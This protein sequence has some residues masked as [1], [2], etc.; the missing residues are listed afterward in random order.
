MYSRHRTSEK[1][2]EKDMEDPLMKDVSIYISAVLLKACGAWM[3][4]GKYAE[5]RR[6]FISQYTNVLLAF[7][8]YVNMTDCYYSWGDLGHCIFVCLIALAIVLGSIKYA[9]LNVRR[10]AVAD[11]LQSARKLIWLQNYNEEEKN[12]F[13]V[14]Q[15]L[16]KYYA[17]LLYWVAQFTFIGYVSAPLIANIGRNKS[18]RLF[19]YRMW[20]D[21]PLT[22][23]PYYELTFT[24]QA[25]CVCQMCVVYI[26]NDTICGV[27]N[28]HII[29]QF[30]ILQQRLLKL[31]PSQEDEANEIRYTHDYYTRM[32]TCIRYHQKLIDFSNDLESIFAL[33]ILAHIIVFSMMM[34]FNIFELL[35][36]KVPFAI[37][38]VSIFQIVGSTIHVLIVTY[39][40]DGLMEESG[41]VG[42]VS[43]TGWW[44]NC[45]MNRT[46][47]RLRHNLRIIMM[48][49]ARPCRLTAGGFFPVTMETSTALFSSTMSYF[50]LIRNSSMAESA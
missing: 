20:L 35:L 10:K 36:V 48:R 34:C 40:C 25:M 5:Y 43:Y 17:Y 22:E 23:T 26:G 4:T 6:I 14:C 49:S 15:K 11:I 45:P 13:L 24:V 32:K 7:G 21:L 39:M 30:R 31:W 37:Q 38:V 19:P 29:G 3:E 16:S 47:V 1:S 18:D 33:P 28:I 42:M 41:N 46:G 8:V 9:N 50:T 12:I 44:M 2:G 27:L